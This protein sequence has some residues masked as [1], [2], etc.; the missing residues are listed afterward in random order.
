MNEALAVAVVV[1][2]WFRGHR[3]AGVDLRR[4]RARYPGTPMSQAR[5]P[6]ATGDVV[7]IEAREVTSPRQADDA[8]SRPR[9]E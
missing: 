2:A 1:R 7:D 6:A 8:T 9:A 3:G 5:R 4:A